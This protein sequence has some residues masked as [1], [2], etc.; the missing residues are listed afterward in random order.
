MARRQDPGAPRPPPCVTPGRSQSPAASA[1]GAG[2]A[3]CDSPVREM[4]G[5]A[6]R[7]PIGQAGGRWSVVGGGW[8]GGGGRSL[9]VGGRWAVGG[10]WGSGQGS[11]EVG[12]D[13]VR[14]PVASVNL[15]PW[16]DNKRKR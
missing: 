4:A 14:T 12:M 1:K 5:V 3:L 15:I 16:E 7:D 9:V 8:S 2:A 10:G 13:Q 6:G 11:T